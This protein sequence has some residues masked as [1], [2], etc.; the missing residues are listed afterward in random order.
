M[1]AAPAQGTDHPEDMD[2][3]CKQLQAHVVALTKSAAAITHTALAPEP[4]SSASMDTGPFQPVLAD[5]SPA[6]TAPASPGAAS[7]AEPGFICQPA[8]VPT[9]QQLQAPVEAVFL[10]RSQTLPQTG[11]CSSS[12]SSGQEQQQQ[13]QQQGGGE[14]DLQAEQEAAGEHP[15]NANLAPGAGQSISNE[16]LEGSGPGLA[17]EGWEQEQEPVT[18]VD[19]VEIDDGDVEEEEEE[20][21]EEAIQQELACEE[22]VAVFGD[23]ELTEE[24]QAMDED[25]QP[26]AEEATEEAQQQ[27]QDEGPRP[28]AGL[29][30]GRAT[31][32]EVPVQLQVELPVSSLVP[33]SGPGH[34]YSW[35]LRN[36]VPLQRPAPLA[37]AAQPGGAGTAAGAGAGVRTAWAVKLGAQE[38]QRPAKSPR[39]SH[40]T[41][42]PGVDGLL[43]L[44]DAA[45]LAPEEG[46]SQGED[47][48]SGDADA[49]PSVK[50][51]APAPADAAARP[52][53]YQRPATPAR[54]PLRPAPAGPP[55]SPGTKGVPLSGAA[56]AAAAIAAQAQAA[57]AEVSAEESRCV[58]VVKALTRSDATTRR[59][60]LPRISIEANLPEAVGAG[61]YCIAAHDTKGRVW[62]F[63]LRSWSNGHNPKPVYVLEHISDFIREY[64]VREGDVMG[65]CRC[66]AAV[67]FAWV[68]LCSACAVLGSCWLGHGRVW[69]YGR[70]L[71]PCAQTRTRTRAATEPLL[72]PCALCCL[73]RPSISITAPLTSS[74]NHKLAQLLAGAPR[75]ATSWWRSTPHVCA[76]RW[77]SRGTPPSR[78][79]AHSTRRACGTS[80]TGR[81][82]RGCRRSRR[83]SCPTLAAPADN[84]AR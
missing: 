25:H 76:R 23:G 21:D 54:P 13:L 74:T 75:P 59:M 62:D 66:A 18:A 65:L 28:G 38:P 79:S 41:R 14:E 27:Q 39:L 42:G 70:Q 60:I 52:T 2:H 53:S 37:A 16:D 49:G 55:T 15:G 22:D 84:W 19:V 30:L 11:S 80:R 44:A 17:S 64:D 73:A 72:A 47:D 5:V 83:S 82:G 31:G 78:C 6:A 46:G 69:M 57:A 71:M 10:V 58:L 32:Q 68:Q 43:A 26:S 36:F 35:W 7:D 1:R 45:W 63:V 9:G 50:Q 81:S 12:T 61:S 56:A 4:Q 48:C 29:W 24:G 8:C 3:Q 20:L 40:G 67:R 34:T 77:Y 51:E 33:A